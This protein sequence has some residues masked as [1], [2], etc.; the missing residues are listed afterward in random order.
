MRKR[1]PPL[2][3]LEGFEAAARLGSFSAAAEELNL[4]QS[5]ISHQIRLLENSLGQPVFRRLHRS[6]VLTDAG[7]DFRHSVTA[8][9]DGL[10]EGVRRLEPYKKPGSVV[11]YCDPGLASGW[12]A[13]KLSE[14][15]TL[16]PRIDVW[17]VTTTQPVDFARDEVDI[18]LRRHLASRPPLLSPSVQVQRLFGEILRPIAH[19]KLVPS[20]RRRDGG[21]WPQRATLLHE[22]DFDGWP[23]WF[24]EH[25]AQSGATDVRA[26]NAGPNF[27]DAFVMLQ[28]AASGLGLA[29]A[30]ILI[31]KPFLDDRRLAWLSSH[32]ID[33]P[34][35]YFISAP[36]SALADPDSKAVFDWIVGLA[37]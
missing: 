7:R 28:A 35:A 4:T 6:V 33:S 26:I 9:L 17:L 21:D 12:L 16:H 30:S 15:H 22:E 20:L 24:K 36:D 34:N 2:T 25:G 18:L 5:A 14:L 1:L 29:L 31:A 3:S 32:S 23:L 8:I 11:V 10:R 27:S 19:P 13:P 37:Q